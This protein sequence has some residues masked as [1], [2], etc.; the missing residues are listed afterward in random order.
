MKQA[1]LDGAS[2]PKEGG[3]GTDTAASSLGWGG[4]GARGCEGKQCRGSL[5]S[6]SLLKGPLSLDSK[7]TGPWGAHH[8]QSGRVCSP[9]HS[10][11]RLSAS[12]SQDPAA[13]APGHGL[14]G[15]VVRRQVRGLPAGMA[16]GTEPAHGGL[17]LGCPEILEGGNLSMGSRGRGLRGPEIQLLGSRR[18]CFCPFG[19][20][21]APGLFR[22]ARPRQRWAGASLSWLG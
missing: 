5:G 8:W 4:G 13:P 21:S 6:P 12:R 3:Q 1:T 14:P 7:E 20:E 10:R 19:G 22:A 16:Q 9:G 11:A 15:L 2:R 18:K 17:C